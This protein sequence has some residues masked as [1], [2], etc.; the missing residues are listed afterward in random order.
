MISTSLLRI[1]AVS[2]SLA[3]YSSAAAPY[4]IPGDAC[5]PTSAEL[6]TFNNTI[7]GRLKSPPPY[8]SVCYV[9]DWNEDACQSLFKSASS[10]AFRAELPNA[11]MFTNWEL[12]GDFGCPQPL[13]LPTA[14]LPGNCTLGMFV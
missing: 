1:I 5:F 6:D 14:P 4:C 8:A 10:G 3:G 7:S 9:E 2:A 12:D 11:L 13:T